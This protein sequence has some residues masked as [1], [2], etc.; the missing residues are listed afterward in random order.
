ML[1]RR[2]LGVQQSLAKAYI[3]MIVD[4][5]IPVHDSKLFLANNETKDSLTF[6]LANNKSLA[7]EVPVVTITRLHV[8]SNMNDV[9][10]STG[11]STQEETDTLSCYIQQRSLKLEK[12][13]HFMTQDR[14]YGP[15]SAKTHSSWSSDNHA[16]GNRW[17]QKK[18]FDETNMCSSWDIKAAELPGFHC[19]TGCETCGHIKV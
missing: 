19:L 13:V 17:Q 6:C 7:A 4:N 5:T 12:N 2:K 14:Y 18:Y 8:K 10:P 9:Q 1:R 15:C 16:Y 3:V 11:V